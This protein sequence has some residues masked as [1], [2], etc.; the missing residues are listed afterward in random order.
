MTA[1]ALWTDSEA[2]AATGGINSA[3]WSASGVSIDSRSVVDGDLFVAI[4]GPSM[5]GHEFA[6]AALDSGASATVTHREVDGLEEHGPVLRVADTAKALNDLA[7]AARA[8]SGAKIAAVTGSVGKTGTKEM[9]ARALAAQGETVATQGNLN[10]HWG[11]P[12]S[13]TRLGRDAE[14]GVFEMGMNHAG[15]IKP[16]SELARPH[17]AIVTTVDAVHLEYFKDV[18]AIAD[19]KAEIFAGLE[20]G[21]TAILNMDNPHF[22]RLKE[23]AEAAGAGAVR[24]FGVHSF[25][26]ARLVG[27]SD[28]GEYG[29][30]QATVG[31]QHLK[32]RLGLPGHHWALNS[33]AVM[34]AVQAM[35]G[36]VRK[37][38]AIMEQVKPPKGRGERTQVTL[39]RGAFTLIDESYNASPV[40]MK[41]AIATQGSIRTRAGGRRV[42]VLGDMLELGVGAD[43]EH[44]G[45]ADAINEAN[46]DAVFLAGPHMTALASVLEDDLLGGHA[47]DAVALA[48]M[49]VDN[50]RRGD[51][52]M[53]KGSLGSRMAVIVDALK[54]LDTDGKG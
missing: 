6:A 30:V 54:A 35:G 27:Y 53:V 14:F 39:D 11:L 23:A 5:D 36:D 41:A 16:L 19:A 34:A 12:L 37:A 42:A 24:A 28:D 8:R 38:A 26:Q 40:S 17:V 2:A 1:A 49:V 45:L 13:L 22:G 44:A 32:Y 47:T 29:F 50:I 31:G 7:R 9:L 25:A 51:V 3:A 18:A 15:E 43:V 20:K 21:G 10:N 46:I 52:V 33:L 4:K 48:P